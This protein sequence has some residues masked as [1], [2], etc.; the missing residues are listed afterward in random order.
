[1]Q[2][3]IRKCERKVKKAKDGQYVDRCCVKIWSKINEWLDVA[4]E[5]K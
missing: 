1:M 3:K 2:G 4:Q 5:I